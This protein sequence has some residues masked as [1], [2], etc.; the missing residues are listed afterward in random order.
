MTNY[1]TVL[2][3]GGHQS[4]SQY[5]TSNNYYGNV[6]LGRCTMMTDGFTVESSVSQT[7]RLSGTIS[8]LSWGLDTAFG[9]TL[10][11]T[12]RQN[13][14]STTLAVTI[15]PSTTGWVTD[16]SESDSVSVSSGDELDF[17]ANIAED[18]PIEYS[19]SFY[20][21]SASFEANAVSAQM[22]AAVGPIPIYPTTTTTF[23]S[24]L[25]ILAF[26]SGTGGDTTESEQ[27]F[28][29]FAA[30][31]W[32]N[33]ACHLESNLFNQ[34]TTVRNRINGTNGSMGIS[35]PAHTSG[36]FEDTTNSDIVHAG[37]FIDYGFVAS[38]SGNDLNFRIDWIG[39]HFLAADTAVC[40][41]GGSA[42]APAV[43]GYSG[44][45]YSSLFGGGSPTADM[46]RS[47]GL[48][49]YAVTASAFTNHLTY[50]DNGLSKGAATF[51]L[52]KNGTT[53]LITSSSPGMSGYWTDSD[54]AAFDQNDICTNRIAGTGDSGTMVQW[55]S[56]AM[57]LTAN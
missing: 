17:N 41:I 8:Y 12:L 51:G 10:A 15:G 7:I 34:A 19:G 28:K 50:S 37:D 20:C 43:I 38:N 32:R 39:A 3:A 49:P 40:V 30:G 29:C 44:V 13:Y 4:T 18:A 24:F 2:G 45:D 14:S 47:T 6:G 54:T 25:G 57:L 33:M 16:G 48:F 55:I 26:V 1:P 53:A 31:T 36:Y 22:L 52:L 27:Q 46:Y 21:V 11:L 5:Y 56:A 9:A 23:V 42:P 35:I